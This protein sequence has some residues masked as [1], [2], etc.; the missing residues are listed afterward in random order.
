MTYPMSEQI[1][2]V[3]GSVLP[4]M[5]AI[6]NVQAKFPRH[7]EPVHLE[8]TTTEGRNGSVRSGAGSDVEEL[9]RNT[10]AGNFLQPGD[11]IGIDQLHSLKPAFGSSRL[12][13]RSVYIPAAPSMGRCENVMVVVVELTSIQPL[14]L[15]TARRP[16]LNWNPR[17][18]RQCGSR[19]LTRKGLDNQNMYLFLEVVGASVGVRY[20][21]GG[22]G[23]TI[24]HPMALVVATN[25]E[26][27]PV[28]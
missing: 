22:G 12:L 6:P 13:H 23:N 7:G 24:K 4:V 21:S 1:R 8:D 16:S 3:S 5:H 2:E 9:V 26:M 14:G 19:S 20:N 17:S 11:I 27:L 28:M 15:S 10:G 18:S 25:T